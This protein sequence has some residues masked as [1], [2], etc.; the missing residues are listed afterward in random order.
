MSLNYRF[1]IADDHSVVRRGVSFVLKELYPAATV[2]MAASFAEIYKILEAEK[3]DL[4]FLDVNFPDGSSLGIIPYLKRVKPGMKI[5]IFSAFDEEIYAV[6]YL[7]AGANGYL[8]KLCTE[9][10]IKNAV[11]LIMLSGK[12]ISENIRMK[13]MD[14]FIFNNNF[15]PLSQ[16]SN[17]EIEIA[18]LLVKGHSNSAICELLQLKKTT[19]STYK[20]RV[21]EKLEIN[22]LT[23][24]INIFSS[25]YFKEQ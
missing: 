25:H 6:R 10:D 22:K 8:N 19:V 21:F 2:F 23:S 24:L 18:K 5:L 13:I 11:D 1:I 16:L 7:S 9:N 3:V 14:T 15:N 17:R 12:Y 20:R 4:L